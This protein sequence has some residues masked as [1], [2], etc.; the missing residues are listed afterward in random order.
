[1]GTMT[2]VSGRWRSLSPLPLPGRLRTLSLGTLAN[3]VGHGLWVTGAALTS[4][5]PWG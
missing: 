2:E 1:M 3:T 4:L 5:A